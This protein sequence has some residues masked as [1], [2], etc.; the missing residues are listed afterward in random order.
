MCVTEIIKTNGGSNHLLGAHYCQALGH[1]LCEKVIISF[2]S[3]NN[4]VVQALF[5][6]LTLQIKKLKLNKQ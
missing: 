2:K 5:I 3:H 1:A 6:I 4:P